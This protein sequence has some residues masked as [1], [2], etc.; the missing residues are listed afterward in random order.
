[1]EHTACPFQPLEVLHPLQMAVE[2]RSEDHDADG[3]V[4][5]IVAACCK[6]F[7]EAML[8]CT[9]D[10][11]DRGSLILFKSTERVADFDTV[12][13]GHFQVNQESVNV[14]VLR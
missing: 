1:M 4:D 14:P 8:A 13:P 9:G 7:R 6:S 12:H 5:Q 10:E 3:F 2:P 11:D